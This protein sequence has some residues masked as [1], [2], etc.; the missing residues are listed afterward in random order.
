M[1]FMTDAMGFLLQPEVLLVCAAGAVAGVVFGAIPGL[2]GGTLLVLVLPITFGMNSN[3]AIALLVAIWVG[4]TSGSFIGSI[5]LGIPG[6]VGSIATV[7]DGYEFTKQGDP[8]RALSVGT[9]ANFLGTLPSLMVALVASQV[10]AKYAVKLGPWEFFALG[11]CAIVL[12]IT[13]SKGNMMK[14]LIGAALGLLLAMV[15]NSPIC[16]TPRFTFG[17]YFLKGGFPLVCIMMGIFAGK[18]IMME[19]A[20]GEKADGKGPKIKIG[21]FKL[22]KE[23]FFSNIKNICVSFFMGLWIG[24]LPGMGSALSNVVAY[25]TAKNNS[26]QP[27]KFGKGCIDGVWAPEVAN[28]ASI[29]GALIPTIALGIPGDS[30]TA[31]MLGGLIIHGIEAGPLLFRNQPV[32]VYV[33]FIAAALAAVFVLA[34]EIMGMRL[35]PSLLRVPYHYLYPA[36]VILC[37]A[38]AYISNSNVIILFEC[39]LFS[40]LGIWM[41]YAGIPSSP[42][43]LAFVLCSILE[44][45]FRRALSYAD[46]GIWSF[47]THPVSCVLIVIAIGSVAWPFI[48]EKCFPDKILA[49]EDDE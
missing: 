39:V 24:F 34:V 47:F 40:L 7:Y 37:F 9:V 35:F 43:T 16:G 14:G 15:G 31:L 22:K 8:V 25:A 26:K 30:S 19:Y 2:S 11:M 6:S 42:F 28:N 36:I 27:E 29:G 5:L 4:G 17:S 10:I 38:G 48:R 12:V 23:D 18:I 41:Q 1:G 45:N 49:M 46:N 33:I 3:M 21:G 44:T 32:F 20:R 13:L